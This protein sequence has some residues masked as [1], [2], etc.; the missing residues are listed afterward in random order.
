MSHDEALMAIRP[1]IETLV[2][3][4]AWLIDHES[5]RGV[6]ELFTHDGEYEMGP[7]SLSGRSEIEEFYRRRHAA[8]PRTSRHLFTNLRLRDVDGDSVRG[9][10]VLSL[11]AANGVPPHPL[12]PV[13]VADYDDE[14]VRGED[15]SWLFRRRT[16]T[17]LFGEPPKL[18][19]G[20][21]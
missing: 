12:S 7:V 3:E 13:I 19:T 11:H 5:G 20:R 8:G 15:G 16:V 6:A 9:T 17:V 1:S 4:F 18:P 2:A 21:H 14:Y 10:C